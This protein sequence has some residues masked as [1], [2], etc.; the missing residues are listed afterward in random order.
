MAAE[1][2]PGPWLWA[3]LAAGVAVACVLAAVT[4]GE[5]YD[6]ESYRLVRDALERAPLHVYTDFE[7]QGII[8][9]PYPPGYFPLVDLAGRLD[10]LVAF[11]FL[12]RLPSILATAAIAWLVQDVLGRRGADA[13]TRLAA[14]A[15][16]SLGPAFLLTAG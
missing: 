13:R 7:A 10:G 5:A 3:V 15:L 12:I 9:W 16:V 4:R 1:S 14:A 6:M 8:R 11:D 2:R